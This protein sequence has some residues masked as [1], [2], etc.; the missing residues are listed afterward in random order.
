MKNINSGIEKLLTYGEQELF[1][2]PEGKAFARNRLLE[3]LQTE[4]AYEEPAEEDID[5]VLDELTAYAVENGI[6]DEEVAEKFPDKLMSIV[7]PSQDDAAHTYSRVHRDQ[8]REAAYQYFLHLMKASKFVRKPQNKPIGWY[9]TSDNGDFAVMIPYENRNDGEDNF[10][11]QCPYCLENLG[12]CGLPREPSFYTKRTLPF[13]LNG[14]TWHFSYRCDQLYED[15]FVVATQKHRPAGVSRSVAVLADLSEKVPSAFVGTTYEEQEHEHLF[16]GKRVLPIFKRPTKK[17]FIDGDFRVSVIDWF[18]SALR[19]KCYIK[20]DLVKVVSKIAKYWN[21]HDEGNV[22]Y[23]AIYCTDDGYYADVVFLKKSTPTPIF[24]RPDYYA[25]MGLFVLSATLRKDIYSLILALGEKKVDFGQINASPELGKYLEW[26]IQIAAAR[27][28]ELTADKARSSIF[29]MIG[30]TCIN[31]AKE[32]SVD[33]KTL[34]SIY[35][36]ALGKLNLKED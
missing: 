14:E 28:T 31:A 2:S 33:E 35:K 36:E 23:P 16:G 32:C 7:M 13:E 26:V 15:E 22:V 6:V 20:K 27:G 25:A 1:L 21:D 3:L 11:P 4:P 10:Y 24:D 17:D 12:F 8:G 18:F 34:E 30:E 9:A 5:A 29:S 19:I